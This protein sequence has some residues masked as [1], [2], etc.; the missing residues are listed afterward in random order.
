MLDAALLSILAT[1]APPPAAVPSACDLLTPAEVNSVQGASILES[2]RTRGSART[3]AC[4]FRADPFSSSVSL[5][6]TR[7]AHA[8]LERL[9]EKVV[10]PAG[11]ERE[12][13]RPT[14]AAPEPVTGVGERAL[15]L[16]TPGSGTLLVLSGD[17]LLRLSAGGTEATAARPGKKER[18]I[19]LGKKALARLAPRS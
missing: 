11:G 19:E 14:R 15:W 9:L 7:G 12:E 13:E 1:L 18:A 8:E 4:F 5:E 16:A 2:K 6:V 3:D 17:A 10:E